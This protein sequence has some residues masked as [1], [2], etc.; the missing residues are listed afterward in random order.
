MTIRC[1]PKAASYRARGVCDTIAAILRVKLFW[2]RDSATPSWSGLCSSLASRRRNA[3][4]AQ[5]ERFARGADPA[6]LLRPSLVLLRLLDSAGVDTD[7]QQDADNDSEQHENQR[8]IVHCSTT[9]QPIAAFDAR[10]VHRHRRP[11]AGERGRS[12]L[13]R[14]NRS[15]KT[16]P[17]TGS[18]SGSVLA[19]V[20][21]LRCP[22]R[23][24]PPSRAHPPTLD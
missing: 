24:R 5:P 7:E 15:R 12:R 14:A 1:N 18:V 23:C 8:I 19:A 6:S 17:G 4:L 21:V 2:P 3:C 22:N 16:V 10:S 9:H 11:S 13:F 20:G